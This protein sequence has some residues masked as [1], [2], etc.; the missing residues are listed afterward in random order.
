MPEETYTK[1]CPMCDEI[2]RV[3]LGKTAF[4]CV[5]C[6]YQILDEK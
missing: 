6:G 1:L 5:K 3:E 2:N 4:Q